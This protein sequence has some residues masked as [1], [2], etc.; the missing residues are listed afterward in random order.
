VQ[1]PRITEVARRLA[2]QARD[3]G[4][5][6]E[7]Y[8]AAVLEREVSARNASGAELRIRTAGFPARKTVED[9][10]FDAQ[11]ALRA[12]L[13]ALVSRESGVRVIAD[14]GYRG[15]G[16]QV[17]DRPDRSPPDRPT[18]S[19]RSGPDGPP[20]AGRSC[21]AQGRARHPPGPFRRR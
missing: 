13:G 3:A 18:R 9:F 17:P 10:D 1:A 6:H 7:D 19:A 2:D 12:P 11:P 5:T 8:L 15:S 21:R 20:R 4:W 14:N 16:F